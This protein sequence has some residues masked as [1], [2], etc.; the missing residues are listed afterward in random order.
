VVL[1]LFAVG[2]LQMSRR[3]TNVGGFYTYARIGLGRWAGGAAAYLA[4]LAYNAATIA[5]LGVLSLFAQQVGSAL[6]GTEMSWLPFAAGAFVLVAVLSYFELTLSAKVLGVAL[7]AE[8]LILLVFDVSVLV[9]NGFHGFSLDVFKPSVVF[10]E[11]FGVSLMLAI[12]A[13]VGFEATALYGEEA[14]DPRTSV[15]RATYISLA[16]VALFY[17]FT[18]WAAIS[19][20]GVD[21]VK[22]AASK[23]VGGFLF[24]AN[25]KYVGAGSTELMGLLVVSSLFAAFLA[26]H[27]HTAR[28]HYA[29]ARDGLLPRMLDR[30]SPRTGSPVAASAVQLTVTAVVVGLTAVAGADPYLGMGAPV[31]GLATLAIVVLQAIAAV[32]IVAFFLRHRQGESTWSALVAPALGALGLAVGLGFWVAHYSILA[33]GHHSMLNHL[34]WLLPV[35]ATVGAVVAGS[36]RFRTTEPTAVAGQE[37]VTTSA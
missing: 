30:T 12:G 24:A 20:Y 31:F 32:S 19:A 25:T 1:S 27:C 22:S 18:T 16:V 28:Y 10:G 34:P 29:L 7:V 2:Y 13:F 5:I 6:T 37:L 9:Q 8:V 35:V 14:R 3:V 11:G 17:L 33:G 36:R 4:L 21:D 26:F 23:D 15:P